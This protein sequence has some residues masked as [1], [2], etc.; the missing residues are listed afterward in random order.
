MNQEQIDK[1]ASEL[2]KFHTYQQ[3]AEYAV[4]LEECV[5]SSQH[6]LSELQE[7]RCENCRMLAI[8]GLRLASEHLKAEH[9]IK[10]LAQQFA[11]YLDKYERGEALGGDKECLV[12]SLQECLIKPLPSDPDSNS[13][14]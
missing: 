13:E 4:G 14:L 3:L 12:K 6:R 5:K 8:E 10:V 9:A 1:R 11:D 2:Q 7:G